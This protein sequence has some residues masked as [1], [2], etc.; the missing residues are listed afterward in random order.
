VRGVLV[1]LLLAL[2][3]GPVDPCGCQANRVFLREEL[4]VGDRFS[5]RFI[6]PVGAEKFPLAPNIKENLLHFCLFVGAAFSSESLKLSPHSHAY[7]NSDLPCFVESHPRW[8]IP[9]LR[10]CSQCWYYMLHRRKQ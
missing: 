4:K 9:L 5:S 8:K 7:L 2:V 3:V 1:V 6:L 10:S